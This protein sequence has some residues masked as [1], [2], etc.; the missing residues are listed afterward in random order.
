MVGRVPDPSAMVTAEWTVAETVA[1]VAMI[2]KMYTSLAR[3]DGAPVLDARGQ[4][5]VEKTTVDTVS[6]LNGLVLRD[7]PER[8]LGVLVTGLLADIEEV[9]RVTEDADP[10]MPLDW[11]GGSKVPLAGVLAHL[12]NELQIHGWDIAR[13]LK[14]PWTIPPGDAALFFDLFLVGVLNHDVGHLLD[15]D[16]P[17]RER[18]IA[19]AFRSAYTSPVVLVLH[20]GRV[21]VE[22]P[23]GPVD[24]RISFDP[25]SLNL[26]LFH[27]V[28]KV[29][30]A[31][32]G[33]VVVSG[34]RPWL[35]PA[36]LRVVR[37][38]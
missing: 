7:F 33:K 37:L 25:P 27:R 34:P 23:G 28:G 32:T 1:H 12:V 26:M 30:S 18:R 31:L 2:A 14:L 24:V 15:T 16:A 13:A 6:V 10:A 36:F 8:D 22:E 5:Q 21:T 9:L 4:S 19:V 35:L 11:L 17:P 3:P 38:P 20:R 29:R